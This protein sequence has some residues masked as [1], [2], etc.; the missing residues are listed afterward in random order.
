MGNQ[1]TKS[2]H[3]TTRVSHSKSAHHNSSRVTSDVI[4]RSAS[5]ISSHDRYYSE[6]QSSSPPAVCPVSAPGKYRNVKGKDIPPISLTDE[7]NNSDDEV[8]CS[9]RSSTQSP[10]THDG[11]R[12]KVGSPVNRR[13]VDSTNSDLLEAV[14]P[15]SHISVKRTVSSG[16]EHTADHSN[17]QKSSS[18]KFTRPGVRSEG[19]ETTPSTSS[20]PTIFPCIH[21]FLHLTQPQIIFVRK[22]W[23][24]ARNQGAL[25]PAIS[26][27]RNS[28]FKNPEIRQMIMFGTKNEGHERLKR[29]AQLFTVLMDDLIASL[30]SPSATV[31]GLR[32]AGEK[33]VWPVKNQYGCPFH[34]HLMDQFA[35]AMIERTLEWG[36]KKD[37]TETTQRGWTKIVLFVTEQLKEGFQ[38][39]QKRARR[40]KAQI[41]TSAGSA[42]FEISS[43]VK[44][45]DMKRFHTVDNM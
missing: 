34:A 44:Q 11:T 2:S 45:S 14:T 22:T 21:Q 41:K 24:H 42:S 9:T 10:L 3:G 26:I 37:R 18:L 39:E 7:Y 35:T 30:D 6:S 8:F 40:M 31:A 19:K 13:S 4:P 28:F 38:D 29:H 36:E 43:R 1:S 20:N 5:A 12:Q 32:E 15:R 25:E 23:S 27:F 17:M 16:Q 33:H